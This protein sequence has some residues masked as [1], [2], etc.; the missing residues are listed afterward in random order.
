MEEE[1][2]QDGAQEEGEEGEGDVFVKVFTIFPDSNFKSVIE[3]DRPAKVANCTDY[4]VDP[5][6]V[7]TEPDT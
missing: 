6:E 4:H 2:G 3:P 7:L 5:S 1:A